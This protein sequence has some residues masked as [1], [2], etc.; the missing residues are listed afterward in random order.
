MNSTV[1]AVQLTR[2]IVRMNTINPP[3][4]EEACARRLGA[5]LESVGFSVAYHKLG[6]KRANLVARIGG[7]VRNKPLCF[8]GHIDTVPLGAAAW[9]K[10]PFAGETHAGRLYGRGTSD[11]KCGVAAFVTA[12]V[13]LGRRLERSAG[14]ELVITA[15]EETGC[16]GA[17]DLVRKG[18]LGQAGA[19][20]VG[21]PTSNYPLVGHKG[22]FWLLAR[23]RGVTAHGSM[24]EKG[25]NAIYKA[26]RALGA[27]EKF[28]FADPAHALM[29]QSTLNVGTIRGGL[30]INSV[31]DEAVIAIDIR[32][33]PSASH[34]ELKAQLQRALG[35]DVELEVLLDLAP[36]Y[37]PPDDPWV[38]EVFD[39]MQ[40]HLGVR[41]EP[42]TA[43]YFT[44]AAALVGA[45]RSPPIV[46]LGPG[47]PQMAHQTDEYCVVERI[48]VAVAAY[49]EITRRW[50]GL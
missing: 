26:G 16:Q 38:Q 35:S 10:D 18:A 6:D 25:V 13:R 11:M 47:E 42:K 2:E 49:E 27:L 12:A 19:V 9:C 1:D 28:R 17:F 24:P 4:D 5:L 21:E 44:D 14:L 32:S 31:P 34:A 23:T 29:G 50:C 45:Y 22:A 30:N 3:G 37:T 46:I 33:V 7:G 39:V 36:V 48:G 15:G 41:P 40:S 8:T 20:L 43:S